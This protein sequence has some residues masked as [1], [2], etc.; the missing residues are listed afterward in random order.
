MFNLHYLKNG[1]HVSKTFD[2][3]YHA[4]A[5]TEGNAKAGWCVVGPGDSWY[6]YFIYRPMILGEVA[7]EFADAG[8]L[9][10]MIAELLEENE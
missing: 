3:L 8:G 2:T 10:R 9:D 4:L 6:P 1:K 5:W 7:V